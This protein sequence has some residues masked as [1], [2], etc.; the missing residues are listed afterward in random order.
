MFTVK[1]IMI[2]LAMVVGLI[3]TIGMCHHLREDELWG[4]FSALTVSIFI[5]LC[6]ATL[7][8]LLCFF[9]LDL[10]TYIINF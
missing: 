2:V 6:A 10:F 5:G 1:I 9:V 3:A 4:F 8:E 7:A